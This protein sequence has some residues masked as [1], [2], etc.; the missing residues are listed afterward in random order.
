MGKN[1]SPI[2]VKYFKDFSAVL[3]KNLASG[4]NLLSFK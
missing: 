3:A 2:V 1:I 4:K